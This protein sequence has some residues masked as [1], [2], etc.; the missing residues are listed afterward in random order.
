MRSVRSTVCALRITQRMLRGIG[1]ASHA[2][3]S[4]LRGTMGLPLNPRNRFVKVK[5]ARIARCHTPCK[6][7]IGH[8][9]ASRRAIER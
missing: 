4:A 3:M 8:I 5:I 7:R 2:T 1:S 6:W 9:R